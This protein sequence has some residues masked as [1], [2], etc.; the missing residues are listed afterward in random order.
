MLRILEAQALST[1]FREHALLRSL[2]LSNVIS[3]SS[4]PSRSR[5]AL[6]AF[7]AMLPLL[8]ACSQ[9][10]G[11]VPVS[12]SQVRPMRMQDRDI[13]T[14]HLMRYSKQLHSL[15]VWQW[16]IWLDRSKKGPTLYSPSALP[17]DFL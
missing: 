14:C 11:E 15:H 8:S 7:F 2:L 13:S 3:P 5:A 17:S 9:A 1:N 4:E 6:R 10:A 12:I 16:G